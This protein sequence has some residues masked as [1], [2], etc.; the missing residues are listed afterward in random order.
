MQQSNVLFLNY[1]DSEYY[2][3]NL[4]ALLVIATSIDIVTTLLLLKIHSNS[5]KANDRATQPLNL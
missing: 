5:Q 1:H 3:N 2:H 4:S